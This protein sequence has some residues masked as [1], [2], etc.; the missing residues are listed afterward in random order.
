MGELIVNIP[1][2]DLPAKPQPNH[3]IIKLVRIGTI[4]IYQLSLRLNKSYSHTANL[5]SGY[6][7]SQLMPP[8]RPIVFIVTLSFYIL[9]K[10]ANKK[11][12]QKISLT[13]NTTSSMQNSITILIITPF[14]DIIKII[15]KKFSSKKK[16]DIS[17]TQIFHPPFKLKKI[18]CIQRNVYSQYLLT[19]QKKEPCTIP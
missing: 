18:I 14:M 15:L 2:K 19:F 5:I 11:R 9:V 7:D 1:L 8:I 17:E 13:E 12:K 10:F 3:P 4:S 6:A 16:L